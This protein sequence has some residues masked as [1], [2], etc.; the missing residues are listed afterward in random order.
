M[1]FAPEYRRRDPEG[2]GGWLHAAALLTLSAAVAALAVGRFS[3]DDPRLA[4]NAWTY[5]AAI[6]LGVI[7]VGLFTRRLASRWL[8]TTLQAAFLISLAVHLL[9]LQGAFHLIVLASSRATQPEIAPVD[10]S[11]ASSTPEEGDAYSSVSYEPDYAERDAANLGAAMTR[12]QLVESQPL[13]PSLSPLPTPTDQRPDETL[14]PRQIELDREPTLDDLPIERAETPAAEAE[15]RSQAQPLPRSAAEAGGVL[16]AEPAVEVPLQPSDAADEL[17]P[18]P[19]APAPREFETQPRPDTPQNFAADLAVA[20]PPPGLLD[21]RELE[22]APRPRGQLPQSSPLEDASRAADLRDRL[23]QGFAQRGAAARLLPKSAADDEP[24]SPGDLLLGGAAVELPAT[25]ERIASTSP[26]PSDDIANLGFDR[27]DAS[28]LRQP[29]PRAAAA[30]GGPAAVAPAPG[31]RSTDLLG[32]RLAGIAPRGSSLPPAATPALGEVSARLPQE[33][34]RLAGGLPARRGALAAP[35]QSSAVPTAA[36]ARRGQ[37]NDPTAGEAD[38]GQWGPQTEA[39]I[40]RGLAFLARNQRPDGSWTLAGYS[41]RPTLSSDTAAT[42]LTLLAFQGAGYN[43]MQYQYREQCLAAIEFLIERQRPNGD[44]YI[45]MDAAS[46][47]STRFYSHAIAALA[48]CEAFGMTQD[49]RLRAPAQRSIDYLAATQDPVLG[50]WRYQPGRGTDTSVTGWCMMALKS[51]EL[52][53]LRV[54]PEIYRGI[55]QY[56]D[57]AAASPEAQ[58]LYRYNPNAPDAPLRRHGLVPTPTMTSVGLL[59][60]FYLGWRRDHPE[61]IRGTQYL[62]QTPPAIGTPQDPQR[63]TYYWYYATQVLFHMGGDYWRQWHGRLHPLLIQSQVPSGPLAGSWSPAGAVPDRWG[64]FAGRLYVT[65]MN[66][67]SL[68]VYYRH[69]PIYE[70]AAR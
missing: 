1:S 64:G 62:L 34:G 25:G 16:D 40:E 48:L 6:P 24:L 23:Q 13:A 15:I 46:D 11:S 10:R 3:F 42:G 43:H 32:P 50:G 4:Y 28:P 53:G 65:T 52:A 22:L 66:L 39:A 44:L 61:M 19:A 60:R 55:E 56:L 70:E 49:E 68:E 7:A 29:G 51:A 27:R 17:P 18:E 35:P 30:P 31:P 37:R 47:A 20:S 59:I 36:F 26:V 21:R 33:I 69:L 12:S 5:L 45:P 2:Q 63:D 14:R 67:L 54:D 58:H 8:E 41:E 9:A 38:L 57:D